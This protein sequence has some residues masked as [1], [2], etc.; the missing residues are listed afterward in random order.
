M[1]N[2]LIDALFDKGKTYTDGILCTF[3]FDAEILEN[4][5]LNLDGFTNFNNICVFTDRNIYEE[6]F[7]DSRNLNLRMVNK[8]YYL[9]PVDLKGIFHP[10][11]YILASDK[12]VRIGIGS[13]NLTRAGLSSNLE[14]VSIFE[15]TQKDKTYLGIL[16]SCLSF[17]NE[18]A[19][20][21][22][23]STAKQALNNINNLL[24]GFLAEEYVE[25]I[26]FMHNMK[27]SIMSQVYSL[28][29]N[30]HKVK[31]IRVFSPFYDKD[32]SVFKQLKKIYPDS[33][34]YF[35][36]QQG[37]SNFPI[38]QYY[39][40]NDTD[41]IYIYKNQERYMHGKSI[42]FET[43]NGN[44]ALTGSA[45]FTKS[46]L[47]LTGINGNIEVSLFGTISDN[48][49]KSL[50]RP[51]EEYKAIL[52]KNRVDLETNLLLQ[53]EQKV[54]NELYIIDWLIEVFIKDNKL[55]IFL[56]DK[57]G[58]SPVRVFFNG[59]KNYVIDYT[60]IIDI[61][62]MK[63]S[64]II[65]AQ[66]AGINASGVSVES[67]K[68]WVNNLDNQKDSYNRK[69]FTINDPSELI[70]ILKEI[71]ENGTEEELIDFIY[72]FNIPL[73]LSGLFSRQ[74]GLR[75]TESMGN[76][77]GSI[78][79]Q[80]AHIWNKPELYEAIRYFLESNYNKLM[81]HYDYV[82]LIH[83][84]N[85]MLIYSTLFNMMHSIHQLIIITNNAN[86]AINADEWTK[87]RSYYDTFLQY[88][89]ACLSLL[90]FSD[91]TQDSFENRVNKTIN[92]D[93]QRM[94]GDITSFKEYIFKMDYNFYLAICYKTLMNICWH[95]NN[96]IKN[97]KVITI[98]NKKVSMPVSNNGYKD[99]FILKRIDIF[100]TA[101]KL[102]KDLK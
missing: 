28:L 63:K 88:G 72:R 20:F 93:S 59:D 102:L 15:I 37:K 74:L 31:A 92:N 34:I 83:L 76:V 23:N 57:T 60:D 43:N 32:L 91:K 33:P 24:H 68:V 97:G 6:L 29:A 78:T 47:L 17:L 77:F 80:Q 87:M 42:I 65:F 71:I 53:V 98:H 5:L 49:S 35:Y 79:I 16:H 101:N 13:A 96:F 19:L 54:L 12:I 55:H 44:F 81:K 89:Q 8:K 85:F 99:T 45:N 4:Y 56:R 9:V 90:W 50:R 70:A 27:K 86:T 84:D 61:S 51:N 25:N 94:L 1:K 30:D 75:A 46:A 73:D 62:K 2:N 10:K 58:L 67:G 38:N 22:K 66:I 52:L 18:I 14:I 41:K 21:S 64:D 69:R 95:V 26:C 3:S 39:Q 40:L 100:H 48:I 36:V 7:E 11:L 82:Q